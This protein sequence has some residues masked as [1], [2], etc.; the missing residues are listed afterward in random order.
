MD[1]IILMQTVS[2]SSHCISVLTGFFYVQMWNTA[3]KTVCE[4]CNQ[5]TRTS[6]STR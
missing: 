5:H 4:Q 1:N 6:S 3:G 2:L